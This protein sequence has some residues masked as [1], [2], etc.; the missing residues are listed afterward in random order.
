MYDDNMAVLVD[1]L[2]QAHKHKINALAK[3]KFVLSSLAVE[4]G[5]CLALEP[6]KLSL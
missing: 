4:S 5:D 1:F 3:R 2:A 6:L